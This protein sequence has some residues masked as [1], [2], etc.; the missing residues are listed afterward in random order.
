MLK[1]TLKDSGVPEILSIF[2]TIVGVMMLVWYLRFVET[3]VPIQL[4]FAGVI[5]I[6]FGNMLAFVTLHIKSNNVHFLF[7]LFL[8]TF[9]LINLYTIRFGSLQGSDVLFEYTSARTTIE[10]GTWALGRSSFE[11][12][13]SSLSVSL[14]PAL[15]SKITG[16]NLF[17]TFEVIMRLVA[18]MLP[19]TIFVTVKAIFRNTKLAGLSA[20]LFS[21]LYFNFILLPSLMRQFM[22]EIAFVLTILILVRMY[23][24]KSS[25]LWALTIILFGFIF[26]LV[27]Y[28]YTVAYWAV[29]ILLSLFLFESIVPSL[30][31][32][33]LKIMK[34][35]HL[36]RR[37][38]IL[39]VEYFLLFLVLLVSW[40]VLTNIVNFVFAIHNQTFL[41]GSESI[42]VGSAIGKYQTGWLTGSATGPVT[43]AWFLLGGLFAAIGFLYFIFKVPK[44]TRHLPW[45]FGALVMFIAVAI[46]ITPSFSGG[47]ISLDRV[48]L[49]GSIFFTT[50][51][52][53]LLLKINSKLK[54]VIVIF[55][56]L[57]LPINMLLLANQNYVLYQK[58]S[59]VSPSLEMIQNILREPSFVLSE[60]LSA[61]KSNETIIRADNPTG[62]RS[63]F[64]NAQFYAQ[65]FPFIPSAYNGTGL[66]FFHYLNIKYGLW[67]TG[68]QSYAT[69]SPE[70]VFNQ[71]SVFYNNGQAM[72][73]SYPSDRGT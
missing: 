71:T 62:Y 55:L 68:E 27:A 48:Y 56:L 12:Y 51:S 53:G 37:R 23:R 57:N 22:A 43:T 15:L 14:V 42:P 67:Q 41:L 72:L 6:S 25:N 46:W 24:K 8:T 35:S 13:F 34:G 49:I 69:F 19:L 73:V 36:L 54:V 7:V 5:L 17:L 60:W 70:I 63:L 40:T 20:L 59:N 39:R 50:F 4:L 1:P 33:M 21:Q 10:Q 64:L 61:H 9:I 45:I 18:A 32:K 65:I 28:H 66:F 52:A 26:G 47:L 38:R 30:P 11:Y 44:Q 2:L 58:E 31:K 3:G 16:A 29:I